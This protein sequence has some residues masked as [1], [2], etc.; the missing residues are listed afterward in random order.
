[1]RIDLAERIAERA[2]AVGVAI[3]GHELEQL[4]AYFALLE[5]WNG[6]INLTSLPLAAAPAATVDKLVVEPLLAAPDVPDAPIDW[7]DLGTGGGSPAL[8]LKIVRPRAGLMM[9]ESRERKSAFLREAVRS[10]GMNG[11]AVITGRIEDLPTLLPQRLDLVTVRAV[12]L[13][14]RRLAAIADSLTQAGHLLVFESAHSA[15]Y[16]QGLPLQEV[17]RRALGDGRFGFLTTL[18]KT[19]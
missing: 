8:P 12:H 11:A 18:R 13:D 1:M 17:S 3:T 19:S 4:A 5:R 15:P 16:P 2:L 7:G 6:T 9:I 14:A 10:L